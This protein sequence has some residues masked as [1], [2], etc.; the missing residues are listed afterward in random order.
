MA[1]RST[2]PTTTTTAPA[3]KTTVAAAPNTNTKSAAIREWFAANPTGTAVQCQKAMAAQGIEV[4]S[5]HCQQVKN[6]SKQRVDVETIKIAA[7]FVKQNG[8]VKKSL[9]AIDEVGEFINQC[10]SPA[11]A[12]AALEAYEAMA[13]ALS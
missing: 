1:K 10:G 12:K 2:T 13:A 5:S 4:G 3:P 11:K 9:A 7:A 8:D 6:E